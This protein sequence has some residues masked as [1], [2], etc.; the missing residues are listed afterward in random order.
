MKKIKYWMLVFVVSFALA[1]CDNEVAEP[2]QEGNPTMQIEDQFAHV[3]FGDL[4]P[5]EVT[6][7]D[8]VP[9]STLTA[10]LYF[11]EEE[12]SKTIIRTKENGQY[13]GSIAIPYG[14][15]I[16]DGT[17]TLEFVLVN[18][19]L[20]KA[21][22]SFDVPVKLAHYPYLILVTADASYPMVPTG[23]PNEY[24]ASSAFPTTE[25]PAYIKT[26]VLDG[27][28][29]EILFGWDDGQG[30][31]AEGTSN[32]I[33]FVSPEGGTYS[34]TF[35]TR[36]FEA[37]PFFEV[38]LNGQ[39]M[40]M[41]DKDNYQLDID[42]AQGEEI[43]FEG[44]SNWWVD[45]DFFAQ[46]QDKMTFVPLTGRYRVTANLPL[47]Y[48]K[49]EALVGSNL[50]TLQP[51]G[52]GAIWVI[53]DQ[54][55]KPS[56]LSNHVGWTPA[57]ALCMA[58]VGN[59]KYQLTLVA[60]ETVNASQINFKFFHQKDWG[61]EFG[62]QSLTSESGIVFVGNGTNGRDNGN[63]GIVE[64]KTLTAG[65]TYVFAVDVSRGINNAVLTVEEK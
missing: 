55:G 48:L 14:K 57:N 6:V 5:F 15:N 53:G 31:I 60:G 32:N 44:L 26:P 21:S 28:G 17:A 7:N 52:T 16:P 61:G 9:L 25:L 47:N 41:V 46:D 30:G 4:L 18:T 62:S 43:T 2:Q 3:H 8:D 45:P 11:G 50:A 65:K 36:T 27:K 59:K 58:P 13:A 54:V 19:T 40:N 29:R 49:V 64:G 33:P 1:S 23:K 39:K 63:L 24:A 56:Y 38:I 42:L 12:V 37:S 51:D 22:R 20:K 10:K 34:V 35:N